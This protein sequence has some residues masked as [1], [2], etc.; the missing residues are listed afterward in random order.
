MLHKHV[1]Y[2]NVG[3]DDKPAVYYPKVAPT[4]GNGPLWRDAIEKT[5]YRSKIKYGH[6][7]D[8]KVV[9]ETPRTKKHVK[10]QIPSVV[11]GRQYIP[12][13]YRN[14]PTVN[15]IENSD[16]D[17]WKNRS[18]RENKD[19][20]GW[21]TGGDNL[22]S[23]IAN[24][25]NQLH[26]D[27]Y[28]VH[29]VSHNGLTTVAT[30][31]D[32]FHHLSFS[33]IDANDYQKRLENFEVS[34]DLSQPDF[35]TERSI[36]NKFPISDFIH[37]K[38]NEKRYNTIDDLVNE[39]WIS[40]YPTDIVDYPAPRKSENAGTTT[41]VTI[42]PTK[43]SQ[44]EEMTSMKADNA[45]ITKTTDK[46]NVEV[47]GEPVDRKFVSSSFDWDDDY[48]NYNYDN[49]KYVDYGEYGDYGYTTRQQLNSKIDG[50][51]REKTRLQNDPEDFDYNLQ[52][53]Y[54]KGVNR[55]QTYNG[56]SSGNQAQ[57]KIHPELPS[58]II[59]PFDFEENSYFGKRSGVNRVQQAFEDLKMSTN[60]E[61]M[62]IQGKQKAHQS[63]VEPR[64]IQTE[65]P[66]ETLKA[67][68]EEK[69]KAKFSNNVYPID[70]E[71]PKIEERQF[72]VPKSSSGSLP[73]TNSFMRGMETK[74]HD[75]F[76]NYPKFSKMMNNA[77]EREQ[78]NNLE[79][80]RPKRQ[81]YTAAKLKNTKPNN[82]LNWENEFHER[83]NSPRLSSKS[84]ETFPTF[85]IDEGLMDNGF[86]QN[87]LVLDA[88][89]KV[90]Q[91]MHTGEGPEP[92]NFPRFEDLL[93]T[94]IQDSGREPTFMEDFLKIPINK[95]KRVPDVH[96]FSTIN[97]HLNLEHQVLKSANFDE[98]IKSTSL[99]LKKKPPLSHDILP[100]RPKEMHNSDNLRP[101]KNVKKSVGTKTKFHPQKSE[102]S[103]FPSPSWKDLAAT[104]P[105]TYPNVPFYQVTKRP[106]LQEDLNVLRHLPKIPS[107]ASPS[108]RE[109]PKLPSPTSPT[110]RELW[111]HQIS[112]IK[113]T[114]AGSNIKEVEAPDL[115]I[116]TTPSPIKKKLS[117]IVESVPVVVQAKLKLK[118]E[119]K[120]QLFNDHD[121]NGFKLSD[122]HPT[123]Q[124]ELSQFAPGSEFFD[125][126]SDFPQNHLDVEID[127]DSKL[128]PPPNVFPK[129]IFPNLE[130]SSKNGDK[131]APMLKQIKKLNLKPQKPKKPKKKPVFHLPIIKRPTFL[132]PKGKGNKKP[133]DKS[134]PKKKLIPVQP[135]HKPSQRPKN[136]K[137]IT[138]NEY[139]LK[140]LPKIPH[141]L[142]KFKFPPMPTFPTISKGKGN[143]PKGIKKYGPAPTGFIDL[144]D[145]KLPFMDPSLPTLTE[146]QEALFEKP[147]LAEKAVKGYQ[148]LL[149]DMKAKTEDVSR[150]IVTS[151]DGSAHERSSEIGSHSGMLQLIPQSS[152]TSYA[153]RRMSFDEDLPNLNESENDGENEYDSDSE[154]SLSER[155]KKTFNDKRVVELNTR[156]SS[157]TRTLKN[158]VNSMET[159][160][161]D[162][163]KKKLQLPDNKKEVENIEAAFRN[164][165]QPDT[166]SMS[167]KKQTAGINESNMGME[168]TYPKVSSDLSRPE[169]VE[170]EDNVRVKNK[171]NRK[172]G[173]RQGDADDKNNVLMMSDSGQ[174]KK[175]PTQNVVNTKANKMSK[176]Q[177]M[178]SQSKNNDPQHLSGRKAFSNKA[179][180]GD[181]KNLIDKS[182]IK[183]VRKQGTNMYGQY[184]K[185]PRNFGYKKWGLR[186][187]PKMIPVGRRTNRRPRKSEIK[188]NKNASK[189]RY[190]NFLKRKFKIDNESPLSEE[191]SANSRM[192]KLKT[193]DQSPNNTIHIS[194]N[195]QNNAINESKKI[196]KGIQ[197]SIR[198]EEHIQSDEPLPD[199]MKLAMPWETQLSYN[200]NKYLSGLV[201]RNDIQPSIHEQELL[202]DEPLPV[203]MKRVM[204]PTTRSKY[205][206]EKYSS[207]VLNEEESPFSNENIEPRPVL[208]KRHSLSEWEEFPIELSKRQSSHSPK[209][210]RSR[211]TETSQ[212]SVKQRLN[213][214][215]RKNVFMSS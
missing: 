44:T 41:T 45:H 9:N 186:L 80:A 185:L 196:Q 90:N 164:A 13:K 24:F 17:K 86:N 40:T 105:E 88:V 91:Y 197:S 194:K 213:N 102:N 160:S 150:S 206:V 4:H 133:S 157:N 51:Y 99:P 107:P 116:N 33:Q 204:P 63:V 62:K 191:D 190:Q 23:N 132:K 187:P 27:N 127:T 134:I 173:F 115:M 118:P 8:T 52:P 11:Y 14:N 166:R 211:K 25:N 10:S 167:N 161:N 119:P 146:V 81:R 100:S 1:G 152:E 94:N 73:K 71:A 97:P 66:L 141:N 138:I 35:V 31:E 77:R 43:S 42:Q 61:A 56:I 147:N 205:N 148:G 140:R 49:E 48:G 18:F 21:S 36:G 89:Q 47:Q 124:T 198:K 158:D 76:T 125:L 209:H 96:V 203:P 136:N 95:T 144:S 128:S 171:D 69:N 149:E 38:K 59:S 6:K 87:A 154:R 37:T 54:P 50:P 142:P 155:S 93:F 114:N 159:S 162:S 153:V 117:Q 189:L 202:K 178:Q 75:P 201:D 53:N 151:L 163:R 137:K 192:Q 19:I 84:K 82:R 121:E 210:R 70:T 106:F 170:V 145:L 181:L 122:G 156:V 2:D 135:P 30:E 78:P 207:D 65:S 64:T 168:Y 46:N 215:L 172:K 169:F 22:E 176:Q 195:L 184:K 109:L 29:K 165:K 193:S 120:G 143:R 129:N 182:K 183:K 214:L 3:Y 12:L 180:V 28:E 68:T 85:G 98:K 16:N 101:S 57:Q 113:P 7:K 5:T 60:F 111:R 112:K 55:H 20:D 131:R 199:P 39:P 32:G 110:K 179:K 74:H 34:L 200:V 177:K 130:P 67:I 26:R 79:I 123:F 208:P 72:V 139:I 108:K 188:Q 126:P 175:P 103:K 104:T 92:T 58:T 15:P 212:L 83:S 174:N